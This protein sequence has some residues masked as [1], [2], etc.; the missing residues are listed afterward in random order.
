LTH[1]KP[2]ISLEDYDRALQTFM[3]WV[4]PHGR[5][6]VS[7]EGRCSIDEWD[8]CIN[9]LDSLLILRKVET[10]ELRVIANTE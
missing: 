6:P 3:S 5:D 1:Q 10:E 7:C 2:T 9:Y 8:R 4:C